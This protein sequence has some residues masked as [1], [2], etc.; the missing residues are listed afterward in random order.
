MRDFQYLLDWLD[1]AA[2]RSRR[3]LQIRAVAGATSNALDNPVP[4]ELKTERWNALDGAPAEHFG[5]PPEEAKSARRQQVIIDEVGPTV[6][7]GT[8]QGAMRREIDGS[9]ST[10]PKPA[11]RRRVSA[12]SSPAKI[13]SR[14]DA[15]TTCTARHFPARIP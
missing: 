7:Q 4:E 2:D 12:R 8:L 15:T 5:A 9:V 6:V 10:S 13:E 14:A 11:L 3:L 1:E